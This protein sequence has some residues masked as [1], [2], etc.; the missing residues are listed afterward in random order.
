MNYLRT[1]WLHLEKELRL[2][3]RS[4][5]A[6]MGMLFFTLLIVVVFSL[7]FDPT[8]QPTLARQIAGGLLW[9]GLLFASTTALN[10]SWSREMRNGVLDAQRMSP[11]PPSAL[12]LG[13][14]LANF[15]FV[16]IVEVILAPIFFIFFNLHI[17]GQSSMLLALL[18]LGTWAIVVNGTFFAA[19]GLRARSRELLLP[20]ILFPIALPALLAMISAATGILTGE[21]EPQSGLRI[22]GIYDTVYTTVSLL[23]FETILSAE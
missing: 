5:D 2:E 1:V 10:Q 16:T 22:L 19:L 8:S 6:L 21:T 4:R 11:S 12:F 3:F 15:L 9:V 13:K 23:L 14:A 18:P 7:A 17:L 20:L